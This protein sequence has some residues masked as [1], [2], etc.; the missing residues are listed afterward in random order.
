MQLGFSYKCRDY[1]VLA[2]VLETD[3]TVTFNLTN[4]TACTQ[5][6]FIVTNEYNGVSRACG[7]LTRALIQATPSV[8][9]TAMDK[10]IG[11]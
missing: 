2:T 1:T 3:S 6:P 11:L 8:T 5:L 7:T 10:E 4:L 9:I